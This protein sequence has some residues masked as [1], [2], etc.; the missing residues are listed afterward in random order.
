[1][2]LVKD[3]KFY[4]VLSLI[5]ALSCL[6]FIFA[7]FSLSTDYKQELTDN[8]RLTDLVHELQKKN[9]HL[10]DISGSL[11][12]ENSKLKGKL[13]EAIVKMKELDTKQ[14]ELE[15]KYG[16]IETKLDKIN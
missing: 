12:V 10:T 3:V 9:K 13:E 7:S 11:M 6:V 15:K 14:Q 16:G 2:R 4:K 5:L 1:M 8:E